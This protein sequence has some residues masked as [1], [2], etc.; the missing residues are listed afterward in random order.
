MKKNLFLLALCGLGLFTSA[1]TVQATAPARLAT[2]QLMR[3]AEY[4]HGYYDGKGD[5]IA[6]KCTYFNNANGYQ[7][8][9]DA[10]RQQEF[11]NLSNAADPDTYDF[12]LGYYDGLQEGYYTQVPYN[13]CN[14]GGGPG[15]GSGGVPRDNETVAP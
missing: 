14:T 3:S 11:S 4:D 9:Y 15:G 1:A 6:N 5:A 10:A 7:N 12:W 13:P 8:W 2:T